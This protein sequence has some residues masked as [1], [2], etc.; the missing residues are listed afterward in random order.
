MVSTIPKNYEVYYEKR[1]SGK[2][3]ITNYSTETYRFP[4]RPLLEA[5]TAELVAA[6]T[7]CVTEVLVVSPGVAQS[8]SP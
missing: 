4:E 5:E 2:A 7:C 3:R 1:E 6:G 8:G